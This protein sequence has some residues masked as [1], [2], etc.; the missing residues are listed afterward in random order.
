MSEEKATASGR[1]PEQEGSAPAPINPATGQHRDH[2]VLSEA[3]RAKGFIRPVRDTYKHEV[4]GTTTRM[5][6]PIA[7]TYARKP[8]FYGATFCVA[9]GDYSPVGEHGKFVWLDDGTKV[10]T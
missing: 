6:R 3:E 10:G 7:E 5:G 9:C 2:W 8:S 4:C 1:P